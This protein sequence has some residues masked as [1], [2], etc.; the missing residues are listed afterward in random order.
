MIKPLTCPVC[1]KQLPPQVTV[2]SATFPF[3]SE[4]CRNVD[5]LRWSDGKY[6]IVEDIKD[7][8]DFVQE[9]LEKLEELGEAE[10]EDDQESM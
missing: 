7:R 8:P 3:C 4:R 2:S 9:Y 6:A 10:Y 5:L 1:N